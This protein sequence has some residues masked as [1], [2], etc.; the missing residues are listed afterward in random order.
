MFNLWYKHGVG[1]NWFKN[2]EYSLCITLKFVVHGVVVHIAYVVVLYVHMSFFLN[3]NPVCLYQETHV[4]CLSLV[5]KYQ[6]SPNSVI[7]ST[8]IS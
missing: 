2:R 1:K 4:T 5:R 6:L 3:L 8:N 7:D